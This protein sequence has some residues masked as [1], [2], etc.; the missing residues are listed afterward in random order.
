MLHRGTHNTEGRDGSLG[1]VVSQGFGAPSLAVLGPKGVVEL[2]VAGA[3]RSQ[4]FAGA[5]R[6]GGSVWV[7]KSSESRTDPLLSFIHG[8]IIGAVPNALCSAVAIDRMSCRGIRT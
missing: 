8:Y 2:V 3:F 7:V 5:G 4:G 6:P 1:V